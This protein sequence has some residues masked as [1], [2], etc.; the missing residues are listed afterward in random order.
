MRHAAPTLLV[1][2]A[3]AAAAPAAARELVFDLSKP[4]VAITAGFSGSELLLF[5]TTD[6]SG[7]VVVVV[8]GPLRDQVVRRKKRV[9]G[10]WVNRDQMTFEGVPD[11]YTV[12][13]NRPIDEFISREVRDS[14]QIGPTHLELTP[15][16]VGAAPG[17][18]NAFRNALIRN[19]QRQGL[20]SAKT[21]NLIF[22][23]D[24]LF[25]AGLRFP[26]NV[27]VGEY[28]IDVYLVRNGQVVDVETKVL[29]FR[30]FGFEAGVF[31]LA[32]RN[33]LAY[34]LLAVVIAAV[35]GWLAGVV[36]RRG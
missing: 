22:L 1:L 34:G 26:A 17:E 7:D 28:G 14:Y 4:L 11:F 15:R 31:D 27:T 12:A 32:H 30:K 33:S 6:G 10:V 9:L 21:G 35:A 16:R 29:S 2:A 25:R 3:L 18:I 24:K 20:Y 8:R 5:G 19:K 36:F 13:S 23:S